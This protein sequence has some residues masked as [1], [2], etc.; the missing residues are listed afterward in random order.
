MPT[1]FFFN[2]LRVCACLL[3]ALAPS[4]AQTQ[5]ASVEQAEAMLRAGKIDDALR[6]LASVARTEANQ[7]Q[8]N[9]LSGL[10]Y[11]QK[12]DYARAVEYLSLSV[13]A[14]P[15]TSQQY[16]Q[17]VQLLGLS[18]YLLGHIKEAIPY[19]EQV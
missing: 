15:E 14:T 16:R 8:V 11:Y 7:A 3:L 2:S 5:P 4:A 12:N 13:K 1:R 9:H 6:T 10:A 17:A 18:H 19:L